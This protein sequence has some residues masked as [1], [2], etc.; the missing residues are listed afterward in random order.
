MSLLLPESPEEA[1]GIFT[2]DEPDAPKDCHQHCSCFDTEGE[3]CDCGEEKGPTPVSE[4]L[5]ADEPIYGATSK[6]PGWLREPV[7]G[8]SEQM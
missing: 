7:P 5:G 1:F 6:V 2:Q 8:W 3:C 4:G